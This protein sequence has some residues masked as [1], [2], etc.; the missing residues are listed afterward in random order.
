LFLT[1]RDSAHWSR[2]PVP[3]TVYYTVFTRTVGVKTV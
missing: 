1:V 3:C 2:I